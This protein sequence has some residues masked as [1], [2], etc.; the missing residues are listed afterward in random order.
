V[1]LAQRERDRTVTPAPLDA[2][3]LQYELYFDE[4][5]RRTARLDDYTSENTDQLTVEETKALLRSVPEVATLLGRT[6]A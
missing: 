5:E 4:G 3:A 2:R 6:I 1:L